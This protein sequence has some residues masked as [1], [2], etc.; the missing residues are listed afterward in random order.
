[1]VWSWGTPSR[2]IPRDVERLGYSATLRDEPW[3]FVRGRE[4]HAFG[5]LF[6]VY[7]DG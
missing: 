2:D 4:I 6:D 5:E 1:M 7:L 3:Q